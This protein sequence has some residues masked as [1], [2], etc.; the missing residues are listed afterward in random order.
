MGASP[1]APRRAARKRA[2][3]TAEHHSW[4]VDL[5]RGLGGQQRGARCQRD[6]GYR[7]PKGF[8]SAHCDLLCGAQRAPVLHKLCPRN[9][10]LAINDRGNGS[11]G[12]NPLT[13]KVSIRNLGHLDGRGLLD[14]DFGD[15]HCRTFARRLAWCTNLAR[16]PV[17]RRG[18]NAGNAMVLGHPSL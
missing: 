17:A 10:L 13:K 16:R 11:L 7:R 2:G 18:R 12:I 4:N 6:D 8:D 1:P 15:G 9:R 3:Q 5:R 14:L